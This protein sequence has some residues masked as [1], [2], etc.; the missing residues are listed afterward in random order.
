MI[1]PGVMFINII[2]ENNAK[3]FVR[4]VKN[5]RWMI[6]TEHMNRRYG[7]IPEETVQL[8]LPL[9]LKHPAVLKLQSVGIC[10]CGISETTPGFH[11]LR[12]RPEFM[13]GM[14]VIAGEGKMTVAGREFDLVSGR[15]F[16]APPG[17]QQEYFQ[18]GTRPWRFLWF[19]IDPEVEWLKAPLPEAVCGRSHDV[20]YLEVSMFGFFAEV[21]STL[22]TIPGAGRQQIFRFYQDSLPLEETLSAFKLKI[23]YFPFHSDEL[24]EL[25]GGIIAGYLKREI[26]SLLLRLDEDECRGRLE[27]LW[28]ALADRP[29][30]P[31][32]LKQMAAIANMSV[33]TLIRQVR[34]AHHT[35]PGQILY[36]MRLKRAAQ[37]LLSSQTPVAVIAL[38]V[39]YESTASFSAAFK[40]EY[41]F[42]PREYR[43]RHRAGTLAETLP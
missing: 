33:P 22:Q 37:L 18:V 12:E 36:Q 17:L 7:N 8:F 15:C 29:G 26:K 38:D 25:H 1:N 27:K 2:P 41:L 28:S 39:G 3:N 24:A 19:H 5:F 9:N 13:L 4:I 32:L 16:L 11:I 42:S 31:W 14:F 30:K 43:N 6:M 10:M 35:T 20:K 40:K 23:D 34:K 21:V